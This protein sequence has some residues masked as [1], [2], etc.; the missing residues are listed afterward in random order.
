ME[1]HGGSLRLDSEP[2]IGTTVTLTFPA[3]RIVPL[4]RSGDITNAVRSTAAYPESA[5]A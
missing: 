3:E 2:G 1:L 4:D 5:L